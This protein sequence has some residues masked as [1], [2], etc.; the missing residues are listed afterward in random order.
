MGQAS[1]DG[2]GHDGVRG[3]T[4]VP[5]D[6]CSRGG[7][8][9]RLCAKK[10]KHCATSCEKALPSFFPTGGG[11]PSPSHSLV[12]LHYNTYQHDPTARKL[13]ASYL[14]STDRGR[15]VCASTRQG[16]PPRRSSLLPP[17]VSNGPVRDRFRCGW[18][19]GIIPTFAQHLP[20]P[21]R[22]PGPPRPR[23]ITA[24]ANSM[25]VQSG[26]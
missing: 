24:V 22:Y 10:P 4:H 6:A 16:A 18:L 21:N 5:Q 26:S 14:A 17:V 19:S 1:L 8:E 25:N 3:M 23:I 2:P 15:P 9:S 7:R 13:V 11:L 20:P 12:R